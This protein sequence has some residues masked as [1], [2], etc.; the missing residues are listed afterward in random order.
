MKITVL[1][2]LLAPLALLWTVAPAAASSAPAS[3]S[4]SLAQ[5]EIPDKREDIKKLLDD[6]D[7][8]AG[9]RGEKDR[10]AIEVIDRL[11]QEFAGC[12]PKDRAAIVKQLGKCFDERRKEVDGAPDNRLFLASATALGEMG[13]E[14]ADELEKW[15]GHKKHRSDL[16]LQRRLVLSLGKT[17]VID[18]L[19]T[20]TNLLTDKDDTIVGAAAEALANYDEIELDKRKKVFEDL[21]KTL[22][23]AKAGIDRDVND[24]RA[25]ERYDV[26]AAPLLTSL[27]RLSK[28]EEAR[29]P[30]DWQRWWNKNKRED[31]DKDAE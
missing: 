16:T 20:L 7:D 29:T 18:A 12:G 23:S 30:E 4:P 22:M 24:V 9:E 11:V 5:E 3:P 1:P 25:R 14:S 17:K 28:H 26:V 8:L 21:L 27:K 2:S 15:I 10:E 31:W 19:P 6:F 13:P